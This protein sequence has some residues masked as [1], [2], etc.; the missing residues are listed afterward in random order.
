MTKI[1]IAFAA[2]L[3]AVALVAPVSAQERK[4]MFG[5]ETAT[6][7]AAL[8]AQK[9]GVVQAR[10]NV[11]DPNLPARRPVRAT[12][13]NV[14]T[15]VGNVSY[16]IIANTSGREQEVE[17]EFWGMMK[18]N[19]AADVVLRFGVIAPRS[20]AVVNLGT[21]PAA[22]FLRSFSLIMDFEDDGSLSI[23]SHPIGPD[24]MDL[25]RPWYHPVTLL[26]R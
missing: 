19:T 21:D 11:E 14:L 18:D 9:T 24:G 6:A 2:L 15:G 26:A 5:C 17:W 23:P 16:L 3:T 13:A 22:T 20:T 8:K 10:S 12:A 4:C 1:N 7:K 25:S